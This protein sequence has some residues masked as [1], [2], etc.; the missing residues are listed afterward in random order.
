MQGR[1]LINKKLSLNVAKIPV[2]ELQSEIRKKQSDI[3]TDS[4]KLTLSSFI[5]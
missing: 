4:G 5:I 3:E 2:I 1:K